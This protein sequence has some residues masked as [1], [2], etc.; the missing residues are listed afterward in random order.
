MCIIIDANTLSLVFNPETKGHEEFKPVFKWIDK[1][2]GKIVY[3]GTKYEE[4]LIKAGK[5]KLIRRYNDAGKAV[6]SCNRL[7]AN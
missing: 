5:L 1:G 3:G 2:K 6:H 4:E 7:V